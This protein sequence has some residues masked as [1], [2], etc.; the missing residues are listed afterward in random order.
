METRPMDHFSLMVSS[1]FL[2]LF[3]RRT[4]LILDIEGV[5]PAATLLIAVAGSV[6]YTRRQSIFLARKAHLTAASVSRGKA[7]VGGTNE[8][9]SIRGDRSPRVVGRDHGR[10]QGAGGREAS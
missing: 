9:V 3:R 1:A 4:D 10:T 7:R 8:S 5:G 6:I 2:N